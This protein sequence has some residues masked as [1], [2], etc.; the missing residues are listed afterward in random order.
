MFSLLSKD[1][2]KNHIRSSP[3]A[4]KLKKTFQKLFKEKDLGIIVQCNLKIT[5]YLDI[6]TL[7]R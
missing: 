6:Q 7:K 2:N 5:N 3:E 1:I 4:Q